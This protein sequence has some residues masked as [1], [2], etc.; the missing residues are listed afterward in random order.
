M[1]G[2][3][4]EGCPPLIGLFPM[5]FEQGYRRHGT[6]SGWISFTKS[7]SKA[8][9]RVPSRLFFFSLFICVARPAEVEER[10]VFAQS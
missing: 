7:W 9:R 4:S 5:F 3:W 1:G 2:S 8:R 10:C 6:G